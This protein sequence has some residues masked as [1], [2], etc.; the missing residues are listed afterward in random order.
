MIYIVYHIKSTIGIKQFDKE[1]SAKR[2]VTCSNR[3]A[4]TVEYA[5]ATSQDYHTK[6]VHQIERV[7]LLSG[8][9]YSEDSN[10]PNCCS[11]SSETYWSM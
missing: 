5:Y 10:T 2:C 9:K 11:P 6:V 8:Q 3:N 1:S 7:N 4:K